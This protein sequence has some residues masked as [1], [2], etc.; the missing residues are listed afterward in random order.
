MKVLFLITKSDVGGAQKYVRD[1][2]AS[3]PHEKFETKII[4]GGKD[5]VRFLTNAFR[6]YFLFLNDIA[7]VIEIALLLRKIQPDILHLNSSKAGVVGAIAAKIYNV[8]CLM[9]G[10]RGLGVKIIFTA[11]G[12]VFNPENHYGWLRRHLYILFHKFAALFQDAIINVSEYDRQLA[13]QYHIAPAKKLFTIHNGIDAVNIEFLERAVARNKL[14]EKLISG[15]PSLNAKRLTLN[16]A[17]WLGSVGRLVAEKDYAT[18]I[19][20]AAL[21]KHQT[22]NFELRT[23]VIGDGYERPMLEKKIAELGLQN[24]VFLLGAIPNAERYLKAFDV[25]VLPSIKEGLPYTLLEAMAAGL[26]I[27]ATRTGGMPEIL[28]PQNGL[29]VPPR[30]PKAIADAIK[31]LLADNQLQKNLSANARTYAE[32]ELTLDR[33]VRQTTVVYE[34]LNNS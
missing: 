22:S 17:P 15:V 34:R 29:I 24:D 7:A 27:I 20:A 13:L 32:R 31:K 9:F 16:A 11:H 26:P 30:D 21:L 25:F 6:P 1:L 23:F 19:D 3:L 4:T 8:G 12:W 18:L 5:G 2:A 14:L 10:V 28:E 33:M